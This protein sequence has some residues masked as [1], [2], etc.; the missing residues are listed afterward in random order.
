MRQQLLGIRALAAHRVISSLKE[1]RDKSDPCF[2]RHNQRRKKHSGRKALQ[3]Q[4]RAN[5]NLIY[6]LKILFVSGPSW[7][8]YFHQL[9][10]S[11]D[12]LFWMYCSIWVLFYVMTIIFNRLET[13]HPVTWFPCHY[14]WA[15]PWS[16]LTGG[17]GW[18]LNSWL[19]NHTPVI[20]TLTHTR[21]RSQPAVI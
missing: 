17:P 4:S 12:V 3:F 16:F 6:S 2:Q 1:K 8:L 9:P 20:M 15:H 21:V 11:I 10:L 14:F 18:T 5:R 7:K 19:V 13:F